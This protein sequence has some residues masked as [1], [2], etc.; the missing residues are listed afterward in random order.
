MVK[1]IE[2]ARNAVTSLVDSKSLEINKP[3]LN[4]GFIYLV[5]FVRLSGADI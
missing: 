2:N 1:L 4:Q 3:L 5:R